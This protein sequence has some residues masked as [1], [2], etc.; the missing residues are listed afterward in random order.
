MPSMANFYKLMGDGIGY[1][2]RCDPKG[3]WLSCFEFLNFK[4]GSLVP[5][6]EPP[7]FN[8]GT[9]SRMP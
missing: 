4:G 7:F 8:F 3:S 6:S 2:H 5:T 1:L 9:V